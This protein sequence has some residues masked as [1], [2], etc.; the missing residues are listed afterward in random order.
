[1]PICRRKPWRPWNT[2]S[3]KKLQDAK[4]CMIRW[5]W[6]GTVVK[7]ENVQKMDPKFRVWSNAEIVVSPQCHTHFYENKWFYEHGFRS[8][9]KFLC[10]LVQSGCLDSQQVHVFPHVKKS[11][12]C[13]KEIK[14]DAIFGL[15]KRGPF[16]NLP[17]LA[18]I[19]FSLKIVRGIKMGPK[20]GTRKWGPKKMKKCWQKHREIIAGKLLHWHA[21]ATLDCVSSSVIG[22]GS[23]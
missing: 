3:E 5:K 8:G 1:M 9:G 22:A 14:N 21:I 17:P 11:V 19:K 15:Q 7:R 12:F 20:N 23:K 13:E 6:A 10:M 2:S 16:L 4:R 18:L